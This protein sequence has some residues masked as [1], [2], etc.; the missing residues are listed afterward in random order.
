[1]DS[2]THFMTC[3]C[4]SEHM[5]SLWNSDYTLLRIVTVLILS[6]MAA[7]VDFLAYEFS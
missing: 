5:T 4:L 6:Q 7:D 3:I 1:M 2:C